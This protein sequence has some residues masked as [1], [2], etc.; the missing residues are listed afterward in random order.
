[1]LGG[2]AIWGASPAAQA[3]TT[4][5]G[6][7]VRPYAQTA[8]PNNGSHGRPMVRYKVDVTCPAGVEVEL[9]QQLWEQDLEDREG[10]YDDEY[11]GTWTN[12]LSFTSAGTQTV[13]IRE[14]CPSTGAVEDGTEEDYQAVQFEVSI[15]SVGG[16]FTDLELTQ[17]TTIWK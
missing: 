7:T 3:S 15:G 12:D 10:N 11:F 8:G 4:E 16:G 17:P 13:T 9:K 14:E 1:G 2:L 5:D 6:C